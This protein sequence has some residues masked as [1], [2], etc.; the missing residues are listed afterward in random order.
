MKD[1]VRMGTLEIVTPDTTTGPQMVERPS[2]INRPQALIVTIP[3]VGSSSSGSILN[4][5]DRM[6]IA[7]EDLSN[8]DTRTAL[9]EAENK[10][11]RAA[12]DQLQSHQKAAR[13]A[14]RAEL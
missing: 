5:A 3:G 9:V 2:A 8:P 1:T 12:L 6:I 11:L 10:I 7:Q 13:E 4:H 14:D